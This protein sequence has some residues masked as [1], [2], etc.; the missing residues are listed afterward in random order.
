[1]T[2]PAVGVAALL[3]GRSRPKGPSK[4]TPALVAQIVQ[5]DA[6]GLTLLAIAAQTGLS[7]ATVRVA[8]GRVGAAA[9]HAAEP[10]PDDDQNDDFDDGK[11]GDDRRVAP[12]EMAGVS[13]A[14]EHG[15]DG[16]E[17]VVLTAPVPRTAERA[18]ARF[19]E[20]VEAPVV[21]TEGAHLPLWVL[22]SRCLAWR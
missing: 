11:F 20:L 14:G 19:G 10:L 4:L 8:L 5:R 3:P 1:M 13:A 16:A 17:L 18:A 22:C 15:S 9:K 7:T 6:T 12:A 2:T 21:T